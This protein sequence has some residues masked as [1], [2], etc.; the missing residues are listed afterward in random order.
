MKEKYLL[1]K[2]ESIKKFT[3]GSEESNKINDALNI[4]NTY[5]VINHGDKGS[6]EEFFVIML[7]DENAD[8]AI[9]AYGVSCGL[10]SPGLLEFVKDKLSRA[11]KYSKFVKVPN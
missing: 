7:K 5:G 8:K 10:K 4:L 1:I 11:G 2:K 3:A 9:S 6:S